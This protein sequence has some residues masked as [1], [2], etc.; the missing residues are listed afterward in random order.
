MWPVPGQLT[1]AQMPLSG[2]RYPDWLQLLCL[3][4]RPQLP[5]PEGS[6]MPLPQTLPRCGRAVL[7]EV[8]L[9]LIAYL[10]KLTKE[11]MW[12]I[13]F[14]PLCLTA[15]ILGPEKPHSPSPGAPSVAQKPPAP[16]K[17]LAQ[18]PLPLMVWA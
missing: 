1:G 13:L 3:C 15:C 7:K 12:P 18:P 16:G 6:H 10:K 9:W 14:R 8:Y 2:I 4:P 11:Q 17:K 5:C